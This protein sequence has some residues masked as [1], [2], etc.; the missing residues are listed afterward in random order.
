MSSIQTFESQ[1]QST[2]Q[3]DNPEPRSDRL[4]PRGASWLTVADAA[5]RLSVGPRLVLRLIAAGKL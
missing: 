3:L 1:N 5:V 4:A 2:P